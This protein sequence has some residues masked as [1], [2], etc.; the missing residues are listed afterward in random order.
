MNGAS[1]TTS[2]RLPFYLS[3]S[4]HPTLQNTFSE[5]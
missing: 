4:Y 5:Y 1:L 3:L 2:M